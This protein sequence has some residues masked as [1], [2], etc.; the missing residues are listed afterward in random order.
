MAMPKV[1]SQTIGRPPLWKTPEELQIKIDECKAWCKE[2]EKPFTLSR[3]AVFVDCDR[4]TLVNY[5]EKDAFFATIKKARAEAEADTEDALMSGRAP[6][7]AIFSL[8]NN[9]G[10]KDQR[11]VTTN[12]NITIS[13]LLGGE[14]MDAIE[15]EVIDDIDDETPL[16]S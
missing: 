10:W 6:V 11:E 14:Q 2:N 3:L 12:N 15:G 5:S 4:A 1:R 16:L 7:G 9:F 8:K 13:S